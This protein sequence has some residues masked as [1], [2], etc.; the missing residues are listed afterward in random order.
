MRLL[1]RRRPLNSISL[2]ASHLH[3]THSPLPPLLQ[4]YN[5]ALPT[6]RR[7]QRPQ[8]QT[9]APRQRALGSGPALLAKEQLCRRLLGFTGNRRALALRRDALG[10]VPSD[11]RAAG[12]AHPASLGGEGEGGCLYVAPSF[13]L[14]SKLQVGWSDANPLFFSEQIGS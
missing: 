9:P 5:H 10:A 11:V 4:C 13:I 1:G 12:F 8:S 2:H 7:P 6:L 3:T 14:H